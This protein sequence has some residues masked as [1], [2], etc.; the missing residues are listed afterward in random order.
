[1]EGSLVWDDTND[2]I[3]YCDGTNWVALEGGSGGVTWPLEASTA[4]GLGDED[5]P[6]FVSDAD[7]DTGVHIGS[8]SVGLTVDG[9]TQVYTAYGYTS[10]N[11]ETQLDLMVRW[12]SDNFIQMDNEYISIVNDSTG[13]ILIEDRGTGNDN[14]INFISQDLIQ[15]YSGEN[16][17]FET[18]GGASFGIGTNSPSDT[19]HV[20]GTAVSDGWNVPSDERLKSNIVQIE[21][22]MTRLESLTGASFVYKKDGRPSLGLIAQ[23]VETVF[24]TAVSTNNQSGIKSVDYNQ[25]IAPLIEAVKEL[26]ARNRALEDRVRVLEAKK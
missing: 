19:L 20:V 15:F 2:A 8:S 12:G 26:N 7:S 22:A 21:D 9:E 1:M 10:I 25:L 14:G 6:Q 18:T 11:A 23:E 5:K 4:G 16:Y 3:A 17:Y 13:G 24:P